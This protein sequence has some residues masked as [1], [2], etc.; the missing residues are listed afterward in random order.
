MWSGLIARRSGHGAHFFF[1][2]FFFCAWPCADLGSQA[3]TVKVQ[4]LAKLAQRFNNR[5]GRASES[6]RHVNTKM[7]KH[8]FAG[9]RKSGT[10]DRR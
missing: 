8:L 6:D 5:D 4:K 7:P 3:A 10:N 9:K 2:F 1:F